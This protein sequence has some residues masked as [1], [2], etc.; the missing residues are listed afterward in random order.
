MAFPR[1]VPVFPAS[2][3]MDPGPG[4]AS[5]R[6]TCFPRQRGDGPLNLHL[7]ILALEFSP[8]ARGWT[9]GS[10]LIAAIVMFSPPARGWTRFQR[11]RMH[12]SR[13]FPASAGMDPFLLAS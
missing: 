4:R 12:R 9:L 10:G 2:A 5:T 6:R 11:V 3:G 1:P 13:V 8:P 7:I